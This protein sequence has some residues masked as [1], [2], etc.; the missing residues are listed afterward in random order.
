MEAE[1]AAQGRRSAR[2]RGGPPAGQ[3][4]SRD[5][6][7]ARRSADEAQAETERMRAAHRRRDGQDPSPRRTG[8]RRRRQGRAHG[9]EALRRGTGDR[10]G[11]AENPRPHDSRH[12][13]TPWCA[14]SCA[15][16]TS[17]RHTEHD[18]FSRSHAIRQ[19]PCGR[20]HRE[21]RPPC[22]RRTRWREL[23]AFEAALR[24]SPELHNALTTPA[25][26]GSRKR[27]VVG[28]IAD[29]LGLSRIAR[30]FLFVL[31]DHRRIAALPRDH[32]ELSSWC[33]TSGWVLRAPRWLGAR[34]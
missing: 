18:T 32:P 7:A 12:R 20:G 10:A 21:R 13:R 17:R 30:N 33:W 23:R 29:H 19:C 24:S 28:R 6:G 5:R 26:P 8:N 31:V 15:I 4:G 11:G 9:A 2:R 25:V 27:A 34:A 22:G 14:A 1:E 16:S 3:P